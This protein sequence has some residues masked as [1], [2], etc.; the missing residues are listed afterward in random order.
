MLYSLDIFPSLSESSI[1]TQIKYS[2]GSHEKQTVFKDGHDPI[3]DHAISEELDLP[4]DLKFAPD[5]TLA[6]SRQGR[7]YGEEKLG[8]INISLDSLQEEPERPKFYQFFQAGQ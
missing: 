4:K 3:W 7:L 6:L 2:I 5:L 1:R 8:E